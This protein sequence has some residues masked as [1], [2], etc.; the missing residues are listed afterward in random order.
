LNKVK[1]FLLIINSQD[2]EIKIQ[3]R[4]KTY[5][6]DLRNVIEF[7]KHLFI[8][9]SGKICEI[10]PLIFYE[11]GQSVEARGLIMVQSRSMLASR[12]I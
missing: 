11:N 3:R 10:S 9:P 8:L 5:Q 6:G 2:G 1:T 7:F 4:E 12:I